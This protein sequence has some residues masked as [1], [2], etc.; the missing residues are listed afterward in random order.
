MTAPASYQF[1]VVGGGAAGSIVAGTLAGAGFTVLLIEAGQAVAPDDA[2]VWDPA[3]WYEVL[4]TPALEYGIRS[5]PQANLAKR[6]LEMLQSK[7]LGGCQIHNAMVYVRGGRATYDHWADA[8]GCA[9]W[10]YDDLLT[11]FDAVEQTV[12][13]SSPEPEPTP[14]AQAFVDAAQRLGLPFNPT[15]NSGPS[16]YGAVPFQFTVDSAGPRRTTA[17][18]KYVGAQ[19]LPTLTIATGCTVRRLDVN[20]SGPPTVEYADASG[21]AVTVTPTLEVILS[22][23]AI[24]SP[25]ILLRS[26]IGPA[27]TLEPL[28]IPVASDLPGVGQNFYDDLG[29]GIPVLPIGQIPGQQYGYLG[30]G[31]FATADGIDPGPAPAFGAVDIEVQIST[32]ELPGAPQIQYPL[33]KFLPPV[34]IPYAALGASSLHLK[35][36]GTVTIASADP[37]APPVV[38]PNWLSDPADLPHVIASLTLLLGLAADPELA[39][40][41]GWRPIVPPAGG[42][43]ANLLAA[44]IA[45][46]GETVQ[47]YVGSCAMGPDAASAVVDPT[48]RVYG[49]SG[50]RV[51]DASVA[52]T[53]VTG[54]TAGVSMVIGARGAAMVLANYPAP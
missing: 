9:G 7:G 33:S 46:V 11:Y 47:H 18:E 43:P 24:F 6:Q 36:R 39:A 27:A 31:A 25:T 40:A 22:A 19:D 4:A 12:G 37:D 23:G 48:L 15:Y 35:S 20:G 52:P 34:T 42:Y 44:Y 3:R 2:T 30:I 50:L 26:G 51:I 28:G 21:A 29:I 16:E 10:R 8:L 1:V 49:V 38:D 14:F 17:F 41:G 32:S 53:P 54:N 5:V 45:E 13:I